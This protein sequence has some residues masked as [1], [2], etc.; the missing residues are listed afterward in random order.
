VIQRTKGDSGRHEA[1]AGE[2]SR[3]SD[4]RKFDGNVWER[5]AR[6]KDEY[7]RKREKG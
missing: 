1:E 5:R 2:V 6:E 7:L 4:G 3:G